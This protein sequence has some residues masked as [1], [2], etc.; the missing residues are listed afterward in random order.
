MKAALASLLSRPLQ[1]WDGEADDVLVCCDIRRETRDVSS[2]HFRGSDPG[3]FRHMPGQFLTFSFPIGG[4]EVQR[5]YTVSSPP[6]RP[7]TLAITVKRVS[8]GVVSNWLHDRLRVGDRLRAL[9]PAGTFSCAL[10]PADKYLFLSA[11]SGITPLMSM[12]RSF[13]DLAE[14]PD[15]GFVHAARSVSDIIFHDEIVTISRHWPGLRTAFACEDP[16]SALPPGCHAGRLNPQLLQA[17]VPDLQQREI[18]CCGPSPFMAAVRGML[19]EAGCLPQCYHEES[20]S[21]PSEEVSAP[22]AEIPTASDGDQ[23]KFSIQF[24]RSG[25]R[26]DC[27]GNQTVLE[28]ASAAGM[29]LPASCTRGVCGTCKSKLVSG[30]VEMQHGGGI[31]QREIDGGQ[32]LLC[33]SRPVS[34]VVIER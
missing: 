25:R 21:F 6:T 19:A 3:L 13:D 9:G 12:L 23:P 28:A 17:L 26:V 10:H 30:Q 22:I 14:R 33:C 5:C 18:F 1:A 4:E 8:G 27:S 16:G 11:G 31:R 24:A 34:D 29:R 32:I 20:F 15:L 7:D 2:F